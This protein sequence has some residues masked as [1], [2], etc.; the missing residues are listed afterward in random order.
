MCMYCYV[1]YSEYDFLKSLSIAS[2]LISTWRLDDK[3][4]FFTTLLAEQQ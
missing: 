2:N 3:A 1:F 4:T